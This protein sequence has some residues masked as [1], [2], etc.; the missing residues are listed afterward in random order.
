MNAILTGFVLGSS[1][2]VLFLSALGLLAK[3]ADTFATPALVMIAVGVLLMAVAVA[4]LVWVAAVP[5]VFIAGLYLRL[6]WAAHKRD[7]QRQAPPR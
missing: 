4:L 2:G 1:G 6:A 3:Y 5:L 7:R